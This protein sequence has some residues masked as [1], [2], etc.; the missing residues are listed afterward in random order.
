MALDAGGNVFV[1]GSSA[2]INAVNTA[3]IG[4]NDYVTIAYSAAGVGLWT[5]RY[6][7]PSS[8]LDSPY[9]VA[10]DHDDNVVVTG[11]SY[12]PPYPE[13]SDH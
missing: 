12:G 2:G 9:G 5:N 3:P 7:G 11:R 1:A 10:V 6:D 13:L 4:Y 8:Y